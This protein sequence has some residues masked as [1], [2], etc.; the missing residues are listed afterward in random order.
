MVRF[1]FIRQVRLGQFPRALE[2]AEEMSAV[3]RDRGWPEGTNWLVVGGTVNT[4]ITEMEFPSLASMEEMQDKAD[5]DAEHVSL[6]RKAAEHTIEGSARI[7][8]LKTAPHL[9]R[10]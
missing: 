2:L 9:G 3:Q 4:L 6:R 1:R 7:E 10:S 5:A 8:I